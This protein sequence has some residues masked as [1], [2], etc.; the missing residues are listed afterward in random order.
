MSLRNIAILLSGALLIAYLA[1]FALLLFYQRSLLF[2]GGRLEAPRDPSYQAV[3]IKEADGITLKAWKAGASKPH[4]PIIVFFYGNAG[5]ISDFQSIGEALRDEGYGIV[6]ASYR[7]YDGNPG[8]PTEDG[9]MNDARAILKSLPAD[10]GPIILWGQ[11][12]GSGVAARMASEGRG[13]ALILQ[14][15]YT[16]VV[17]VAARRF[18]IYPVRWVMRDRFNT[19]ALVPKIRMPVLIVHGTKD[20]VVPFDMGE[21]LAQRFGAEATFVAIPNR[22]HNDLGTG[23]LLPVAGE[24]LKEHAAWTHS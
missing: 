17:D 24:W 14:S 18:P 22:G 23:D 13:D 11:S 6:L 9:L 1:V 3:T 2:F 12:L 8:V 10:H 19:F 16:A 20:D 4:A 21:T 15:P 5:A 7:G